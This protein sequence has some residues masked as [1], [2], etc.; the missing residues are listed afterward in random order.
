MIPVSEKEAYDKGRSEGFE[1]G[2]ISGRVT[3][4]EN[5]VTDIP[6]IWSEITKI[7]V[8]LARVWVY[9]TI[10][11]GIA[12]FIGSSIAERLFGAK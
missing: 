11:A 3:A 4:L 8:S 12:S 9:I 5:A 1:L 2:V 6:K 7:R 10:G